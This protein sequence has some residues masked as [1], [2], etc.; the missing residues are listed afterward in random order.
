MPEDAFRRAIATFQSAFDECW[1]L[2]GLG[3]AMLVGSDRPLVLDWDRWQKVLDEHPLADE[4]ASSALHEPAQIATL[5]LLDS[6]GC[7]ALG[8]GPPSTDRHPRLEFL[9]PAA[10]RHDLWRNN[11]RLLLEGYRSPLARIRGLP[12]AEQD[13]IRRLVAGKRL[14]LFSLLERAAGNAD[15]A[16]DWIRQALRISGDDPELRSY[17]RQLRQELGGR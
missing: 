10:Y 4:L 8:R 2:F 9:A 17:A 12:V 3:H 1:V 15:G 6:E 16:V 11:A 14:L 13:R 7:R 5:L